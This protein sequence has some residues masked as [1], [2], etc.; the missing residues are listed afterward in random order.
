M[1]KAYSYLRFSTPE[2]QRGDSFR[3]QTSLA[4]DY[5]AQHGLELDTA[6]T[7]PEDT[8]E[9]RPTEG[10]TLRQESWVFSSG[11]LTTVS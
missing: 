3:R 2:Q 4:A 5:A 6:L 1:T 11:P 7:F 10:R 9:Y 8:W